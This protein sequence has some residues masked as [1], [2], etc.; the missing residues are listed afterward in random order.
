MENIEL[1]GIVEDLKAKRIIYSN[2]DLADTLGYSEPTVSGYLSGRVKVSKNFVTKFEDTFGIKVYNSENISPDFRGHLQEIKLSERK[3][4]QIIYTD[5][6]FSAGTSIEFFDDNQMIQ[7]AYTMDIP[8]FKGTIAFRAYGDSMEPSIKSGSIVFATKIEDWTSHLEYGQVYGIVCND[9]R[10]Y[11]K[12]I[13]RSKKEATHFLLKS[14]NEFYDD[15]ELP[16]DKIKNIWLIHGWL[17][18]RT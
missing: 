3:K 12:Y 18:K 7:S 9:N 13:R 17:N 10:R 2:K 8:E 4:N 16:K 11:L 5:V 6:D 14:E 1:I 15:F